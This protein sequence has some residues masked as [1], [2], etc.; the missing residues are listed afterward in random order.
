LAKRCENRLSPPAIVAQIETAIVVTHL[1]ELIV[2]A[3]GK[4]SFGIMIA[5]GDLAV[6]I[7]CQRLTEIQEEML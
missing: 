4:G 7:G 2:Y 5:R 6:Q 1:P 3:A